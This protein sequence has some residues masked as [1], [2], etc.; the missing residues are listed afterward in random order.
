MSYAYAH[1]VRPIS[2]SEAIL[3]KACNKNYR[4]L[5]V[6]SA[7]HN[8]ALDFIQKR[9]WDKYFQAIVS[10]E[11][12]KHAKPDPEIYSLAIEK[13]NTTSNKVIAIEDSPHGVRSAKSCGIFVIGF[14]QHSLK[15]ILISAGAD[16]VINRWDQAAP[17]L[18]V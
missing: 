16:K 5:L 12:V 13:A 3:Q 7:N 10:G 14:A 11:E 8:I 17:L 2:G 1:D 6:T 15:E 18:R 4:L 9:K